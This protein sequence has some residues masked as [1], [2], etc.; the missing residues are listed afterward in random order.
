MSTRPG[1][2]GGRAGL[3]LTVVLV[4]L[5]QLDADAIRTDLRGRI[6]RRAT[7]VHVVERAVRTA[8]LHA[9]DEARGT[10]DA[11]QHVAVQNLA[12]DAGT[13]GRDLGDQAAFG[14]TLVDQVDDAGAPEDPGPASA[15]P[16]D[17]RAIGQHSDDR[18]LRGLLGLGDAGG[19][20]G[21]GHGRSHDLGNEH[22]SLSIAMAQSEPVRVCAQ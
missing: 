11:G 6:C 3:A 21:D 20:D 4:R 5:R 15:G 7:L 1:S 16:F 12:E 8:F 17:G 2:V 22:S 10:G 18:S 14:R 19:Q 9:L 13:F